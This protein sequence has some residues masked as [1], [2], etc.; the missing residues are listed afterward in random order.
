MGEYEY[1]H[2]GFTFT[3]ILTLII[4][5]IAMHSHVWTRN[6]YAGINT[7]LEDHEVDKFIAH[8]ISEISLITFILI[9]LLEPIIKMHLNFT[10]TWETKAILGTAFAGSGIW[11]IFGNKIK[12]ITSH[13]KD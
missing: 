12:K 3:Y 1:W 9:T 5:S 10:Y 13:E 2:I 4:I 11:A 7:I 8:V 6:G